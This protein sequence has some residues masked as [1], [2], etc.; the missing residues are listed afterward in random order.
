MQDLLLTLPVAGLAWWLGLYLIARDPCSPRLTRSGAGLLIYAS[1]AGVD[2]LATVT[3][4]SLLL[5]RLR[6]PLLLL[7]AL[8]W[9]GALTVLLPET[10]PVREQL[11][12]AWRRAAGPLAAVLIVV[13]LTTGIGATEWPGPL[14]LLAGGLLLLP[15]LVLAVVAWRWRRIDGSDALGLPLLFTIFFG[16]S[17]ALILLP[18][19]WLPRSAVLVLIGVD[20]LG[21]GLSVAR[22]DAFELGE[23]LIPDMIRSFDAAFLGAIVFGGQV[24]LVMLFASGVTPA[25]TILLLGTVFTAITV[26][27][28][29][30]PLADQ[31]DRVVFRAFPTLRLARQELRFAASGLPRSE[32]R[33]NTD[34]LDEATFER[35]VRQALRHVGD[36]PRLATSPLIHHPALDA[37]FTDQRSPGSPLE[38]ASALRRLLIES[39]ERLKPDDGVPFAT[40][41]AWRHYNA[42]YFPYVVGVKP[43]RRQPASRPIDPAAR[44]ALEWFRA[45]VPERTL[46]NWQ[47]AASAL[48]AQDLRSRLE[49]RPVSS[50]FIPAAS[51]RPHLASEHRSASD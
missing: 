32:P 39:I 8:V 48:V 42:L 15:M 14:G 31:L 46:Y 26:I 24:G 36:L 5:D 27:T 11:D 21:I 47:N 12:T 51:I 29:A 49:D 13:G 22:Y 20:L 25:M 6:W 38:R 3:T 50:P 35:V 41:D 28:L 23:A 18:L 1:A 43:Y 2:L 30:T 45:D 37:Q 10:L 19:D 4:D 33:E 7:P 34:G 17:A 44:A 40:S 16:L 9:T